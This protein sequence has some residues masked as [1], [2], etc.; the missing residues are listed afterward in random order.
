V[1]KKRR[2]F[3]ASLK[4][5]FLRVSSTLLLVYGLCLHIFILTSLLSGVYYLGALIGPAVGFIIGGKLLQIFT[6]LDRT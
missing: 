2:I 5:D 1:Q 6:D 3:F 4:F